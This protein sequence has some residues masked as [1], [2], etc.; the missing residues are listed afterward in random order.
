M[1]CCDHR[2][3]LGVGMTVVSSIERLGKGMDTVI[4]ARARIV[5][6]T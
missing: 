3:K 4:H 5:T 2:T 1:G 6:R